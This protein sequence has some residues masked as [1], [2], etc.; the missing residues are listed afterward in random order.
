MRRLVIIVGSISVVFGATWA[1]T[2]P[3]VTFGPADDVEA[4]DGDA[5]PAPAS[6]GA[7][8]APDAPEEEVDAG[9]ILIDG[10]TL[11]ALVV[12]DAGGKVDAS[13]CTGC[14]CDGDQYND[15]GKAGCETAVGAPDCDDTDQRSHPNQGFLFD[16]A[17]PPRNGDWDCSGKVEKL[18]T[19]EQA[20]CAGLTLGLGCANI[21][22][23][24]QPVACGEK[25]TWIRCKKRPGVLTVDCVVDEQKLET[26]LCK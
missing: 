7:L 3:D 23:F 24:T 25:G 1:C 21:F 12:V 26:Q 13:G 2:F 9:P 18:W 15:L 16:K 5:E 11:D 17:E 10:S 19:N 8:D 22:G 4:G 14:D 6:D 20:T